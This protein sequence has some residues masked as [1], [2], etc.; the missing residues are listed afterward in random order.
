MKDEKRKPSY[1]ELE[2]RIA[3]L[4]RHVKLLEN[5]N[6]DLEKENRFITSKYNE[7]LASRFRKSS[8][9]ADKD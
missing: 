9:A 2:K 6:A 1:E 4:E 8:E 3:V 5:A 7:L